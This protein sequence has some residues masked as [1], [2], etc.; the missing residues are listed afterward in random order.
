MHESQRIDAIGP[1]DQIQIGWYQ[2]WYQCSPYTMPK[3]SALLHEAIETPNGS[4][5]RYQVQQ[6]LAAIERLQAHGVTV[7]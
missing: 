5:K 1:V 4:A 2:I 7:R 6:L 3:C